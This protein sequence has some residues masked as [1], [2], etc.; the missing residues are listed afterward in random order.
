[1]IKPGRRG[2]KRKCA[3]TVIEVPKV[4]GNRRSSSRHSGM[5]E[6]SLC[7]Q[8]IVDLVRH[9]D[10]WPFLKLVNKAQ[11]TDYYD[12][13]KKPVALNIIREKLN[14]CEYNFASDFIDDVELMFTNCFEY[15][16]RNTSEAK[17]GMKL[18]AFFHNQVE[19]LGLTIKPT[20]VDHTPQ[21][22]TKRSRI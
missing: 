20:N 18:Q 6:L 19:K 15:N 8:L 11:V 22:I 16:P 1:M 3:D 10:S 9:E 21:P 5:H 4:T 13:I 2:R 7:E 14:R 12:I 17:A